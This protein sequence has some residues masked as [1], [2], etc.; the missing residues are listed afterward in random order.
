[1]PDENMQT[2]YYNESSGLEEWRCRYCSKTY[3]C[4]GGTGI[5][6][7]HLEEFH[8]IPKESSRDTTVKNIQKSL[9][10]A[11]AYTEANPQK[12][13]RLDTEEVSQDKLESLWVR[14]VVSCNLAFNIVSNPEFRAFILYL[15][16][17]AEEFLAKGATGIKR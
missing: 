17:Q 11:F 15:N 5:A 12:R 6:S 13:R 4:S 16:S 9:Q 1:M 7:K 3:L 8:D 14:C 2:I 10:A